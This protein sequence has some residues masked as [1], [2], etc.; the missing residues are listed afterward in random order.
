[1]A[2]RMKRYRIILATL[3]TITL[4]G[5]ACR[6]NT[7]D[8]NAVPANDD[9][10]NIEENVNANVNAEEDDGTAVRENVNALPTDTD[11][12]N[13]NVNVRNSNEN[14]NVPINY[15]TVAV[16][17]PKKDDELTSPF[18]VK[19]TSQGTTV[20]VRVKNAAGDTMFTEPVQVRNNVFSIT[21]TFDVSRTTAGT[22]D[23]FDKDS[24]GNAQNLTVIPVSFVVKTSANL[25]TNESVNDNANVNENSNENLNDNANLVY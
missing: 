16:E 9:S 6:K 11:T 19:G 22:I 12:V 7:N 2:K 23:V 21:L 25:N 24:S 15:G 8:E 10:G 3:I 18:T 5:A 4:V 1:M 14:T 20:Y 13:A 17:Q